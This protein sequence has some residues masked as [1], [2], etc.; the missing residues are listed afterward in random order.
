M[1]TATRRVVLAVVTIVVL[2]ALGAG[3]GLV[4]GDALGIRSEPA[5]SR[6]EEVMS[7]L[8][9]VFSVSAVSP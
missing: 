5:R 8:R 6:G 9:S 4:V 3:L 1:T 7:S 2:I